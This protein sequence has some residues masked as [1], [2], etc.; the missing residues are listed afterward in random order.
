MRDRG[1]TSRRPR[2]EDVAAAIGMSPSSVS[3][4]LSD[5]PGPSE[6]TRRR[7]REAA[8]RLGYRPDRTASLLARRRTRL[9]GVLLDI[10]NPFHAELVE[11][12]HH[13]SAG[14][15]YELVLST[16]TAHRDE[17]RAVETLLDFRCEALVLLGPTGP[18]PQHDLP[19]VAIGKHTGTDI[20]VV[21]A[22]DDLGVA[23]AVEHLVELGHRDITFID[24]GKGPIA[25]L[26][27]RG[28][29]T[30]MRR[31]GLA[32]SLRIV[33][34]GHDELAGAQAG[35][36]LLDS[37]AGS[38]A[39]GPRRTGQLPSA[40]VASNDMCAVGLQDAFTRAG[41]R[42]PDDVSLVGYDNSTLARLAHIDLTSVDQDATQLAKH[43]VEAAA[44]RLEN[45]RT[46]AEEFVLTPHLV[47]RGSTAPPG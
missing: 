4:A 38:P 5:R 16:V 15:G 43:A 36:A 19:V 26:R 7:V 20:D 21:R 29:R 41:V 46:T 32:D 18:I 35:R 40:V 6:G 1:T 42:V 9:L 47:I 12:L 44:D 33:P 45:G 25:S 11:D 24:G 3:L 31:H 39:G 2:L 34:G 23:Q 37:T 17:R 13:A 30:A 22:A 10:R 14:R 8:D 28:Y 27:R